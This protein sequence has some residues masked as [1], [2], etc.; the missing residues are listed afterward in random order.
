MRMWEAAALSWAHCFGW[1]EG[2]QP[3]IHSLFHLVIHSFFHL[4]IQS[5]THLVIHSFPHVNCCCLVLGALLWVAERHASL[6]STL[7]SSKHSFMMNACMHS[8]RLLFMHIF[9]HASIPSPIDQTNLLSIL[10]SSA[11]SYIPSF[12]TASF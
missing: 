4:V 5:L 3:C 9:I 7:H 2:G 11:T 8:S 12:P 1:L 6:H 10:W